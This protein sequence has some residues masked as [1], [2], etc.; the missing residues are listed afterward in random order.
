V[1]LRVATDDFEIV[2]VP[3]LE[4][5]ALFPGILLMALRSPLLAASRLRADLMERLRRGP[6]GWHSAGGLVLRGILLAPVVGLGVVL[7]VI[8]GRGRGRPRS[9]A[10]TVALRWLAILVGWARQAAE[11]A[12]PADVYHAH[13]LTALPA[14]ILARRNRRG[15]LVYDSHELFLEAGIVAEAGPARRVMQAL[16]GRWVKAADAVITVNDSIA[17]EL[18]RRYRPRRTLVLHNVPPLWEPP[19]QRPDLLR[20]TAG[21]ASDDFVALYHGGF[22]AGRGLEQTVEA[23]LEPGL[24]G[25]H[26]VLMGRGVLLDRLLA[27][28]SDPRFG[29]RIHVLPPVPPAE[30]LPWVA[31]ADLGLALTQPTTLNNRLSSPN[32]M[33]ETIATG[34]PIV[35]SDFPEMRRVIRDDPAGPLGALCDPTDVR[36]IGG[37]IRSIVELS[38]EERAALR[39][40]C[41]KAAR[42]RWNWERESRALVD[43]YATLDR[44][45]QGADG[46]GAG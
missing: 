9:A 22:L 37:A 27:L 2:R 41:L 33:F 18:R 3:F 1:P 19:P 16:E 5:S 44:R 11:A 36:A 39:A 26:L 31:S 25:V 7:F 24:E 15:H 28:A 42:E 32:K 12:G 21:I 34:T 13:D 29:G 4:Q 6:S 40:R 38:P 46:R 23:L 14:A 20:T 8:R 10:F 30:L 45:R 17:A 35:M 43:L